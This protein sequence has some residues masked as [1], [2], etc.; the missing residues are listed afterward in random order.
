MMR[1][2]MKVGDLVIDTSTGLTGI[3]VR[4]NVSWKSSEEGDERSQ[5]IVWDYENI[6]WDYEIMCKDGMYFADKDE[7]IPAKDEE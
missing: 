2:T 6:V 1:M 7:L 4:K 3:V 5:G